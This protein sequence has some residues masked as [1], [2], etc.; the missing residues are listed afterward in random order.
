MS[1]GDDPPSYGEFFTR[2][3]KNQPQARRIR[4]GPIDPATSWAMSA[5]R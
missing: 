3:G 1:G 5:E 2:A 4:P